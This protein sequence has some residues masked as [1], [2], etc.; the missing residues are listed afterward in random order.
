MA[1]NPAMIEQARRALAGLDDAD[2]AAWGYE[3]AALAA[4]LDGVPGDGPR[5]GGRGLSRYTLERKLLSAGRR[6]VR[7]FGADLLLR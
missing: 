4:E 2:L 7:R 5:R 6:S 1:G 3:R